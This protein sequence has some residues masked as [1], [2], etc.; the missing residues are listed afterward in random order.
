MSLN[1]PEPV[2]GELIMMMMMRKLY[3]L[4]AYLHKDIPLLSPLTKS[5]QFCHHGLVGAVCFELLCFFLN[6]RLKAEYK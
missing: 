6:A 3:K 4:S 5:Y 2:R 1:V